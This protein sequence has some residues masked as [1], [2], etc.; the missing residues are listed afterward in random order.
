MRHGAVC[1]A[2]F[3]EADLE[4]YR[5]ALRRPYRLTAALNYYRALLRPDFFAATPR[6]HWI[7]RTIQAPALVIWGEQDIALTK[8][9]TYGMEDLFERGFEIKYVP[10]SG[11]WV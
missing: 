6:G 3:T 4:H 8:D 11:H 2:A 9:L 7:N 1:K 10:D 5:A